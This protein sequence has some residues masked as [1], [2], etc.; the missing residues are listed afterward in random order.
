MTLLI[1][2]AVA[3]GF[4]G[5]VSQFARLAMI[6][7]AGSFALSIMT[8]FK[9]RDYP[10]RIERALANPRSITS[11]LAYPNGLSSCVACGIAG[12]R[13]VRFQKVDRVTVDRFV[14]TMTEASVPLQVFS[15][16]SEYLKAL[17]GLS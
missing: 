5:E 8:W 14:A 7:V 12:Q 17:R 3:I 13:L 16:S 9:A 10:I 4:G 6:S 11:A 15:G 2:L 1:L